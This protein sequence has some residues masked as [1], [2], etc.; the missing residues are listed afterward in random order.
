MQ[1]EIAGCKNRAPSSV[2]RINAIGIAERH[3]A[4]NH[5]AEKAPTKIAAAIAT[6]E[7]KGRTGGPIAIAEL[8]LDLLRHEQPLATDH[9]LITPRSLDSTNRINISTSSPRSAS[10]RPLPAMRPSLGIVA[11]D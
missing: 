8:I 4:A 9:Y 11:S 3:N 7:T 2:L 5:E 6:S 10:E 1:L